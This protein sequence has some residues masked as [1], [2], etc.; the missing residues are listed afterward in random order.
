[1]LFAPEMESVF[2]VYGN[3]FMHENTR[4][5]TIKKSNAV[6]L[7][8]YGLKGMDNIKGAIKKYWDPILFSYV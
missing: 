7:N 1:M 5:N 4:D 8:K 2:L 3:V 6:P